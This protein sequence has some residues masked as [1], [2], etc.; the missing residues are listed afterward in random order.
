MSGP[1]ADSGALSGPR[2]PIAARYRAHA[3]EQAFQAVTV[4]SC[5]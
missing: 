4:V 1:I 3:P 5:K 2:E